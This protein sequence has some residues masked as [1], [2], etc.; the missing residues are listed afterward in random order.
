MN[1]DFEHNQ[2]GYR[3]YNSYQPTQPYPSPAPQANMFE[4]SPLE[5]A[6]L[7][8]HYR[9]TFI[10]VII[11]TLGSFILAQLLFSG[12]MLFGYEFRY[13]DEDRAIVDWAYSLM[14]SLPSIVF[15]FILFFAD[16]HR[17]GNRLSGYFSSKPV[18]LGWV[19]GYFGI[20][21]FA[22]VIAY[23]AEL[24]TMSGMF[25]IGVSPVS[26]QYMTE[27]EYS[28]IMIICEIVFSAILAPVAE[29]LLYRGVIL[30]RLCDVS[31]H[32]AIFASAALFGLMHGNLMQTI[33]GFIVGIVFGYA[34]VKTGSLIFSIAGHIFINSAI[35]MTD[36]AD[37]ISGTE[38]SEKI[39]GIMMLSFGAIGLITA[40]ICF[41]RG[42]IR[43]P[44]YTEYHK[45]RTY[46]IIVKCVSFWIMLAY[47][48][49]TIVS[50][51]GPVTDSMLAE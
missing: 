43:F 17:S 31:Q 48:V 21:M 20:L 2:S 44:E 37:Y 22:Y 27:T 42:K 12:A 4:V 11:H 8:K 45:K 15:C 35:V 49:V 41:S 6:N 3:P 19:L 47:L 26:E 40:I 7:K 23:I 5:T 29:E 14:G 1:E 34:T 30:R 9:G 50:A 25:V 24:L 46:P 39:W 10:Q 33:L 38:L 16:K 13:N 36:I 32:F 51:F 28:D 18:T